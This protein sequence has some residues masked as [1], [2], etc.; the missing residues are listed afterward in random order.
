MHDTAEYAALRSAVN[1]CHREKDAGFIRYGARGISVCERWR[2]GEGGRSGFEC[3]LEDMGRKPSPEL[4]LDRINNDGNY[5]PGNCR[6]ATD[7]EQR[8]NTR[9]SPKYRRGENN[10]QEA[11]E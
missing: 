5:E 6:W 7:H 11:A 1:R 9:R 4:S 8:T 10:I 3:F 2:F